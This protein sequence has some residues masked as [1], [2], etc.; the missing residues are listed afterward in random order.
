MRPAHRYFAALLATPALRHV[1]TLVLQPALSDIN[2]QSIIDNTSV[3]ESE[4]NRKA[5][6]AQRTLLDMKKTF[7]E[8]IFQGRK[9]L[10]FRNNR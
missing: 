6:E 1:P 7:R 8:E 9:K 10:K 2:R 3:Q 5:G 4:R